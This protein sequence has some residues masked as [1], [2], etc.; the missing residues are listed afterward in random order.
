[1]GTK[2]H[3]APVYFTIAQVQFNPILDIEHYIPSIQAKMRELHFPDYSREIFQEMLFP[4]AGAQA[5]PSIA[6]Q[7]RFR[8]GDIEGWQGFMLE[9]NKLSFYTTQYDTFETFS[10]LVMQG[11]GILHQIIQLDFVERIGLRYLDAV[12]PQTADELLSAY[13]A[14]EVLGLSHKMSGE[15]V[16]TI[17]ETLAQTKAG[18][19]LTRIVILNG[20]VGLPPELA[21][22][23]SK[24]QPRFTTR[25]GLHAI[26]DTDGFRK[27]REAF[28]LEKIASNLDTLHEEIKSVFNQ[29]VTEHAQATWA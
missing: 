14:P 16:H 1:M 20:K 17:S 18:H 29:T 26:I 15:L 25:A 10:A 13:L 23:T 2:M 12:Q 7:L 8:F 11:L 27:Q 22:F 21:D 6:N 28:M 24:I 4:F 3:N 5:A 9:Q 19:L